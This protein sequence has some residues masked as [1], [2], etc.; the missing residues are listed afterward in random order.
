MTAVLDVSHD[1]EVPA[2]LQRLALALRQPPRSRL[3]G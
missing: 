2:A 1:P 3:G